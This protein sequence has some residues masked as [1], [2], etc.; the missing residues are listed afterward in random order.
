MNNSQNC[1]KLGPSAI[2]ST[3]GNMGD[4]MFDP[5]TL[6]LKKTPEAEHLLNKT[7]KYL[8]KHYK[9]IYDGTM[10]SLL[11]FPPHYDLGVEIKKNDKTEKG[12]WARQARRAMQYV[13]ECLISNRIQQLETNIQ[14]QEP[15][16]IMEDIREKS[17][18]EMILKEKLPLSTEAKVIIRLQ[19]YFAKYRGL[20]LHSYKPETYIQRYIELAIDLRKTNNPPTLTNFE[21]DILSLMKI[22]PSD[23]HNWVSSSMN[24]IRIEKAKIHPQRQDSFTGAMIQ[25]G[26]GLNTKPLKARKNQW[27]ELKQAFCQFKTQWDSQNKKNV[28]QKDAQG[29]QVE[30]FYDQNTVLQKLYRSEFKRLTTELNDEFDVLVFLPDQQLIIGTEVKQA[31]NND[32][33]ANNKQTREAARQTKKREAYVQK[34]FGDL[35]GQGW[36]YVAVIAMYDNKGGLVLNK[37]ADC[38]PFML[39]NGTYQEEFQQLKSLMASLTANTAVKS[40]PSFRNPVAFDSFKHLFSRLIGLSGSVMTIQKLSPHYEIMG[41]D[42]KDLNAG[43]TRASPLKFGLQN[44]VPRE[45]DVFGRPHDVYKLIFY[46]QDQIGLLSMSTKL[47]VFLNDYGAG[48]KCFVNRRY[49]ADQITTN[50]ST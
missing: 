48:N 43:W 34:L 50:Y 47:V 36:Q 19:N 12:D 32:V 18:L 29:N 26:L 25:A 22:L 23:V 42:A 41:G 14:N 11:T 31:M 28:P 21:V 38:S 44:T 17:H 16:P 46:S 1:L 2:G 27:S 9:E 39:T 24:K 30:C 5:L 20:L 3:T 7:E 37:C 15:H 4:E 35:L 6:N 13:D 45:G 10:Q 49:D 40:S 33:K 8:Q